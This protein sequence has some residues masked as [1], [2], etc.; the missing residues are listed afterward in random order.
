METPL[1]SSWPYFVVVVVCGPH[2]IGPACEDVFPVLL[3]F[4]VQLSFGVMLVYF[5][6]VFNCF[7]NE[8]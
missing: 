8:D 3:L 2:C 4:F 1:D 7:F 6:S 5:A